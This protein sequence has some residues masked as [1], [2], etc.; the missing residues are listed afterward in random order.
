MEEAVLKKLI[1]KIVKEEL[2]KN[3]KVITETI[4]DFESEVSMISESLREIKME[5]EIATES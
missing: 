2:D 4:D 3:N 5:I 1:R